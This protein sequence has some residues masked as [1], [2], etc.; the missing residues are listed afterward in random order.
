VVKILKKETLAQSIKLMEL[1]APLVAKYAKAGQF[2][3]IIINEKGERIPLTI[4]DFDK[5]RGTITIVFQEVGKTT[6][7]LGLLNEGDEIAY[8]NGPLGKASHIEKFGNV[9]IIGGGVGIAPIHPISRALK[10]AGNSVTAII[11]S[12]TKDLLF[13]EE[14]MRN[15]SHRLFVTTDDGTYGISGFVTDPLTDII[16]KEKVDRVIAIGPVP[17]MK[18]VSNVTK[19]KNIPTIISLNSLMVC[20][21]G[22]CG[23]C[24]V[25]VSRETRFTCF[26]GPEFDGLDVNLT[27]LSE[28]LKTYANEERIALSKFKEEFDGSK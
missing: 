28:R 11:G 4:A 22:M 25:E 26:E 8:I 14:K 15:V 16:N 13:W 3:I 5:E 7:A 12:R 17:M 27:E 6:L 1:D 21:M 23:A 20:G 2:V 19:G 18:A 9:V 24:R 10:E